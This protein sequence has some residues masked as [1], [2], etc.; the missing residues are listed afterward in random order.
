MARG[1]VPVARKTRLTASVRAT[2]MVEQ[3]MGAAAE[4]LEDALGR[5]TLVALMDPETGEP[6]RDPETGDYI[7]KMVG[8]DA[9]TARWLIDRVWPKKGAVLPKHMDID[10][11]TIEGVIECATEATRRV[12][13][14][15]MSVQDAQSLMD[16][17]LQYCQLRAFEHMDEL[18]LLVQQFEEQSSGAF[19]T[20]DA[21]LVPAWGKLAKKT[22]ETEE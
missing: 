2:K 14:Q 19:T 20:L 16:Y 7:T 22:E 8:G 18:K 13:A 1:P 17:L 9:V 4:T 15:E 5:S 12:L 6:R 11:T 3:L 10:V 21:K